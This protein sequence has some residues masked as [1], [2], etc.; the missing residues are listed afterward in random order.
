MTIMRFISRLML[1]VS[2]PSSTP[3]WLCTAIEEPKATATAAQTKK[4]TRLFY[5]VVNKA[6][7]GKSTVS[8][9]LTNWVSQGNEVKR[10]DIL[11]LTNYF[12]TRKNFHAALQ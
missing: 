7:S 12:R 1:Q 6:K 10:Y 4:N 9:I 11:N 2:S 3:R 8:D 5:Q